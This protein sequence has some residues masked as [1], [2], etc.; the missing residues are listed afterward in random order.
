MILSNDVHV[1]VSLC[2]F[3]H[4][5]ARGIRCPLS[6]SFEHPTHAVGI[7]LRSSAKAAKARNCCTIFAAPTLS[8]LFCRLYIMSA[9]ITACVPCPVYV[10]LGIKPMSSYIR[11]KYSTKWALSSSPPLCLFIQAHLDELRLAVTWNQ[12]Q[13]WGSVFPLFHSCKKGKKGDVQTVCLGA[14]YH[15]GSQDASP[16][17]ETHWRYLTRCLLVLLSAPPFLGCK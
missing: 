5:E 11:G 3:V 15:L 4:M 2:G 1:F 8:F 6:F 7:E 13:T 17:Q 9:Q 14:G 12:R 10:V 16:M